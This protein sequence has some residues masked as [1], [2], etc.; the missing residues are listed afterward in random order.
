[1][2]ISAVIILA[3]GKSKRMKTNRSKLL[4]ELL[5]R[6]MIFYPLSLSQ[7]LKPKKIVLVVNRESNDL[8]A[9]LSG[10]KVEFAIQKEPRGTADAVKS[11][12]PFLKGLRGSALILYGDDPLL[13]LPTISRL[14][15]IHQKTRSSLSLLTALY[16]EPPAFGRIIRDGRERIRAIVEEADATADQ[17][18][19]KEVNAGVY[20][21]E[22][23]FLRRALAEIGTDNRQKEFYLTDLVEKA[24]RRNLLISTYTTPDFSETLGVNSRL[25]L[26]RAQNVLQKKINQQWMADGVTIENPSQVFISPEVKIGL[27]TV[28]ETGARLLG[29]TRIGK[30]CWI[31]AGARIVDSALGDEVV[32]RQNSVIEQSRIKSGANIGP[33]ARVRPGSVVGEKVRIGNFVELKKTSIGAKSAA[34]HLTYL[35]DAVIGRNVN[36]GAGTITCNYDGVNKNP[37]HIEKGVFIGSGTE[38]IA[39]LRVGEDAYVAAGSTITDD[40]PAG[41]LAIARARQVVKKGWA[42]ERKKRMKP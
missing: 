3:A 29:N 9:S 7:K 6:P 12:L 4:H 1:M 26:V 13:T 31:Q 16:L 32:V 33:M 24:F 14:L 28:I 17:R 38:I 40:V 10:E 5:G 27:D 23:G 15:R 21:V 41:S 20:C 36:I 37:T 42:A 34:S 11:A 19:I 30:N 8:R 25:E 2:T 18:Q 22:I 39:P 35:G